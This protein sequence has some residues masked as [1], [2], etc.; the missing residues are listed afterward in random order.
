[1]LRGHGGSSIFD[2]DQRPTNATS[3]TSDVHS[4]VMVVNVDADE[5]VDAPGSTNLAEI[6]HEAMWCAGETDD[7]S[8]HVD[9][10]CSEG[11]D[12]GTSGESDI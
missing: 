5:L 1:M 11:V 2:D 4:L 8:V 12:L 7:G 3:V 10:E 9:N 6:G